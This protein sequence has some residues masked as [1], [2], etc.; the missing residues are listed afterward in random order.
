[1]RVARTE[2]NIAYRRAD[3]ERWQ[4]MDFVLGQRVQMSR[5]HPKKDICD[6]LAGDYPKD[7]VFDGWHPQCFCFVTPIT[8]PPE[9]TEYLTEMMLN[10]EDWRSE[11]ARLKHGREI[12]SYPDNF[13]QWVSD[14]AENIAAA[15]GRG[16]EPYFIRNN[17]GVI[18]NILSNGSFHSQQLPSTKR[19]DLITEIADEQSKIQ[20]PYSDSVEK[21][22]QGEE[23]KGKNK[24]DV[25]LKYVDVLDTLGNGTDIPIPDADWRTVFTSD[26]V[27][28]EL[29][30]GLY[31]DSDLKHVLSVIKSAV[32]KRVSNLPFVQQLKDL[33]NIKSFDASTLPMEWQKE[34]LSIVK[35][36]SSGTSAIRGMVSASSLEANL[37]AY[38][39]NMIELTGNK[40]AQKFGLSNLSPKTPIQL[41]AEFEK[42][43][44]GYSDTLKGW[45]SK[46]FFDSLKYF[47][48]LNTDGN[49][50][51]YY[52][53]NGKFGYVHINPYHADS[54]LRLQSDYFKK[55]ILSH[56]Y[57]H[58]MFH[59]YDWINDADI[60]GIYDK[61]I[62]AVNMD[63]GKTLID[64]IGKKYSSIP[65]FE[66]DYGFDIYEQ[67]GKLSD[68]AQAAIKGHQ[69]INPMGHSKSYFKTYEAQLNEII[70][71]SSENLWVENP[72]FK[73]IA[74]GLYKKMRELI[75]KKLSKKP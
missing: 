12:T 11:L 53:R 9:E 52:M 32:E 36:L 40:L 46:E 59:Q 23:L 63:K 72:I 61:W 47:T 58:A 57:G 43:I 65:A 2:T 69:D 25:L 17:A 55:S 68:S 16:T 41:F 14:N 75:A 38:G 3:H 28:N 64:K 37:S 54:R 6:K 70:A 48:P 49:K 20:I 35:G 26:K 51:P 39:I 5:N 42:A 33:H 18:D 22:L 13:K 27:R 31:S 66:R 8:I 10:G 1:M 73:E 30:Q 67:L 15:R 19:K 56:E 62:R 24:K 7:F 45:K 4:Q 21:L 60:K 50:G 74:P 71:H 29:S 44:P 34:Y